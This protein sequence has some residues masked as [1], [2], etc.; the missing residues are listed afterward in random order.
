MAGRGFIRID[1]SEL[2]EL[3]GLF[4]GILPKEISRARG[5]ALSRTRRGTAS[6]VSQ[7]LRTKGDIKYNITAGRIK[8]G[9]T[10]TSIRERSSFNVIGEAKPISL[11]SFIGTR[12]L[13]R[14]GVSVAIRKGKRTKLPTAF[15]ARGLRGPRGGGANQVF[16]RFSSKNSLLPKKRMSKGFHKGK[17]RTQIRA[18][19]GP[20]VAGMMRVGDVEA[21]LAEFLLTR[22]NTELDR[23]IRFAL[24]RRK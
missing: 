7:H 16:S 1:D 6:R 12:E 14:G 3:E 24:S 21:D 11:T 19:K 10:V 5:I 9:L 17:V 15:I 22:F 2:R 18:L 23:A 13:K 20:S 8:K 4:S